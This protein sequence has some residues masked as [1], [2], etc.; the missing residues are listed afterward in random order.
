MDRQALENLSR[1]WISLWCAPVDWQRFERLHAETFED[2]SAV[3]RAPDK[4]GFALGL[5]ELTK[6]FPDLQTWI[7]DLVIDEYRSR[8]AVRWVAEGIHRGALLGLDPT[9]Q[10]TTFAGIEILEV[11]EG[12]VTGRWGEWNF[13]LPQQAPLPFPTD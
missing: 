12:Q 8:I 1:Q 10:R 6:A 5:A 4:A 9:H 3:G 2:Y 11:A 7:E 13:P